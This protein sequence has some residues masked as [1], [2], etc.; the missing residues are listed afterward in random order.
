MIRELYLNKAVILK[1]KKERKKG[2]KI[3]VQKQIELQKTIAR[4]QTKAYYVSAFNKRSSLL[5]K[6][7]S[8][9]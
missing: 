6:K 5:S 2:G 9:T 1:K 7:Q 3:L 4:C 8:Q